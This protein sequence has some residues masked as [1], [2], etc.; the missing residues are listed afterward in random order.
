MEAVGEMNGA[1]LQAYK[2]KMP[3]RIDV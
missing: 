1:T 2:E 3:L